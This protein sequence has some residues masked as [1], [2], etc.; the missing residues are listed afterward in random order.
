MNK[1]VLVL[2]L[3]TATMLMTTTIA[4]AQNPPRVTVWTDKAEY[5]PGE[6]GTLYIR[7]YNNLASAITVNNITIVYNGWQA[8]R[9]GQLEGN[10]TIALN[11]PVATLTVFEN[12]T[13]FT[14]PTDGRSR[15]NCLVT[16]TIQTDLLGTVSGPSP[17]YIYTAQAAQTPGYMDQ[18]ITLFT[19]QVVLLIVCTIIIAATIFLSA[20][21]P[22]IMWKPEE[23][24]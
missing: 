10:Q 14:V 13:K 16:I 23:K 3:M 17:F 6:T 9:N 19:I 21:R 2:L 1:K 20:H 8:Y 4:Y 15:N 24:Q 7:L 11:K 12:D 18:I 5:A 22:Q